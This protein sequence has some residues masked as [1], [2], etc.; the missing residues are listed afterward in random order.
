[1]M[2][3]TARC[4]WETIDDETL[5]I[6]TLTGALFIFRGTAT[7]LWA[8]FAAGPT[9]LSVLAGLISRRYGPDAWES[10]AMAIAQFAGAE[11][12]APTPGTLAIA[13]DGR[14]WPDSWDPPVVERFDD[15]AEILTLDPIHDIDH[16]LGWPFP[17]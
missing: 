3:D 2:V 10:A 9:D 6:D 12:V 7:N 16:S 4:T 11:L 15:I 1:M 8:A 17:Q 13:V 14:G 5:V